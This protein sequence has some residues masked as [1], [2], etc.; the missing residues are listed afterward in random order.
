MPLHPDV[1]R[2]NVLLGDWRLCR[3][4]VVH[5]FLLIKSATASTAAATSALPHRRGVGS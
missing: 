1:H 4:V 2:W 5:Q 3:A